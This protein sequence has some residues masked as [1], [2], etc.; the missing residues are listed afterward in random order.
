MSGRQGTGEALGRRFVKSF[1]R[2]TVNLLSW[3]WGKDWH[4]GLTR[5]GFIVYSEEVDFTWT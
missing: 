2:R 1:E 3:G 4:W 5:Q